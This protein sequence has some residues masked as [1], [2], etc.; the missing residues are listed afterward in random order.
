MAVDGAVKNVADTPANDAAFGRQTGSRGDSAFPQLRN[1]Y[2]IET[3][4]HA[5]C[6]AI[7]HG[8]QF[9][10]RKTALRLLR[11]VGKGMLLMWD[12]GFHSHE[13]IHG[14]LAKG[15]HF[16][17][18]VPAHVILEPRQRLDDGSYLSEIHSTQYDRKM[19]RNGIPVRVVEYTI[20]D[21]QREGYGETHR[22]ITSILDPK[23]ADG[24]ELAVEYH[25]RWEIEM[26]ID[27]METHQRVR[28]HVPLRSK[29]SLG[30]IQEMYGLLLAHY[31]IRYFMHEAATRVGVDP[32][33]IS[34]TNTIRI[35]RRKVDKF[36]IAE[37]TDLEG[38]YERMLM[39]I[40]TQQ[41]PA[42]DNRSNPRVV[43]RKM[44]K[45]RLK[46]EEHTGI[47]HPRKSFAESVVLLN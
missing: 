11:S 24:R 38:L 47:H 1:V 42:R 28:G 34:F 9:P 25:E 2:L 16:L 41:L 30:V 23:M 22:L 14:C 43:K 40:A 45:Y 37:P 21:P 6:D 19:G 7:V 3:G 29:K 4:T 12:R 8:Y 44:S 46:R 13:M 35:V 32:D 26:A 31:L 36:Q 20:D 18:R 15:C 27:E 10:E 5:I 39:E 33:R 17:G